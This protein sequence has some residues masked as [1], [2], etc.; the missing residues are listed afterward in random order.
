M[1]F[2]PLVFQE[3]SSLTIEETT[4]ASSIFLSWNEPPVGG[5]E[6]GVK[7]Y[8]ISWSSDGVSDDNV[9]VSSTFAEISPLQS[10]RNYAISV[11][12]RGDADEAIGDMAFTSETTGKFGLPL[13]AEIGIQ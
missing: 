9:T 4:T 10:N 11:A 2:L 1:F 12:A 8:V 3:P 13:M 6:Q 7:E 5:G